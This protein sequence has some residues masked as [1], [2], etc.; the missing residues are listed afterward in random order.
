MSIAY[1]PMRPGQED[2][3]A[4]LV[5][6]LP[7]DLRLSV[8]PMVTGELLR[9]W[10][11]HVQ[12]MIA[13]NSGLLVGACV[14]FFTFSTWR[15]SK[16]AHISDLYVMGHMR[17]RKIGQNLLRSVVREAIK[18]DASFLRLDVTTVTPTPR[19]FY[20]KLGF[21]AD[22][23]DLTLFLEPDKLRDWITEQKS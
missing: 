9:Q 15:G 11:P 7:K 3:V 17:G 16:G 6:Q 12:V 18:H 19:A 22:E 1:R 10:Q 14:W 23:E 5:R 21:V 4:T 13:D 20:E 2:A 8:A